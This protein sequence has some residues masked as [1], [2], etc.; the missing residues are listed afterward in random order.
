M[1]YQRSPSLDSSIS[2]GGY[3]LTVELLP[4]LTIKCLRIKGKTSFKIHSTDNLDSLSYNI[5]TL[6][7]TFINRGEGPRNKAHL[8]EWYNVCGWYHVNERISNIA[9]VLHR[10]NIK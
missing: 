3:F 4:F 9:F 8:V 7:L 2:Q 6:V 5:L 10:H 1:W